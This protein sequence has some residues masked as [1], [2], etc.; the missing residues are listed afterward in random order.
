[1][2]DPSVP[3]SRFENLAQ[4]HDFLMHGVM[5]WRL[6]AHRLSFFKAM[7]AIFVDLAS[8]DLRKK[9]VAEERH[10][11]PIGASVLSTRV[12]RIPLS[13]RH[14][15]EFTQI[16]FRGFSERLAAL[17]LTVAELAAQL[18]IPVFSELIRFRETVFFRSGAAIL[19]G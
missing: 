3:Q 6:A 4:R 18:Q 8:I 9:H 2:I 17:Q 16:Q 14:D 12:G 13:L 5:R 19:S 15:V 11:M 7:D 1:M 10:E